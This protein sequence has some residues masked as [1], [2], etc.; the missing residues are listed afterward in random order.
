MCT[1][2]ELNNYMRQ[3]GGQRNYIVCSGNLTV[4]QNIPDFQ[5]MLPVIVE[6]IL[7]QAPES[8]G[9]GIFIDRQHLQCSCVIN[10]KV[11]NNFN[12]ITKQC[13]LITKQC[14]VVYLT[15]FLFL[16]IFWSF[17]RQVAGT[18]IATIFQSLS[19]H[20]KRQLC[21]LVHTGTHTN[22]INTD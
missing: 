11:T 18:F 20:R 19:R 1:Y 6:L 16:N 4:L 2:N 9:H 13:I 7:Q 17:S 22:T 8:P 12:G 15:H 14:S 3:I 21:G 10:A 5:P